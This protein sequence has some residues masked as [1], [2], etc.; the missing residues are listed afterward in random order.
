MRYVL[1]LGLL[2]C[3]VCLGCENTDFYHAKTKDW[4]GPLPASAPQTGTRSR[5]PGTPPSP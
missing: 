4:F 1:F 3:V 2:A 5:A